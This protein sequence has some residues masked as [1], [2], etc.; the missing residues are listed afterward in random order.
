M[1][2]TWTVKFDLVDP[3]TKVASGT[4]TRHGVDLRTYPVT[5]LP[6]EN[7][8]DLKAP[9]AVAAAADAVYALYTA[10]EKARADQATLVAGFADAL[11]AALNAKEK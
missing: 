9:A 11:A 8:A 3:E 5:G 7:A 10:D 6:I 1:A 2:A 4:V